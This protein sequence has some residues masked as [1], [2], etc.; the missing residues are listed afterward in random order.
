M[1]LLMRIKVSSTA[2]TYRQDYVATATLVFILG[3]YFEAEAARGKRADANSL[4]NQ[5]ICCL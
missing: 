3:V 2:V 4:R 5:D 1:Y